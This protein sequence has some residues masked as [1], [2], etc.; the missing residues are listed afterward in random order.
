MARALVLVVED[1]FLVR[2]HAVTLI[3][4]AGYKTLQADSADEALTLLE[5]IPRIRA[6][7][8]DIDLVGIGM[9]GVRLAA[10]VRDRWPPIELLLTSGHLRVNGN[11]LPPRSYFLPKP[12][13][14]RQLGGALDRFNLKAS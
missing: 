5:T 3:E 4:D 12:Y 2:L 7:F 1:E 9:D 8:T 11:D 14:G 6:V 10:V 13:D